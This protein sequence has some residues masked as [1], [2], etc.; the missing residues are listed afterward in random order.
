MIDNIPSNS[1]I[2]YTN[3]INSVDSQREVVK[4]EQSEINNASAEV[5]FSRD[6]LSLQRLIQSVKESPDVRHDVVHA[7]QGQLEAGTYQ[8]DAEALADKLLPLLQ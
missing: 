7:I 5:T 4:G 1:P 3:S 8:V 6:A 2:S